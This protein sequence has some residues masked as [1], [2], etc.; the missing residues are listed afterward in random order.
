VLN[1][2]L[3]GY[4]GEAGYVAAFK[5]NP[6]TQLTT[7]SDVPSL[8]AHYGAAFAFLNYFYERYGEQA[9]RMRSEEKGRGAAGF[10][11][12]LAR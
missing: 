9:L 5:R 6:D 10:N 7:W 3:N 11:Q 8:G 12:T 1:E 2:T 4:G